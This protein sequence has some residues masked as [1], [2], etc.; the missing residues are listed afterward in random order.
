M[1]LDIGAAGE[2][3]N[4]LSTAEAT[5]IRIS[6]D[7]KTRGKTH[8]TYRELTEGWKHDSNAL[9]RFFARG[10]PIAGPSAGAVVTVASEYYLGGSTAY[11]I[12]KGD[13]SA[14]DTINLALGDASGS[15]GGTTVL[16][17]YGTFICDGPVIV[18]A[19]VTL[20][21]QGAATIISSS[22]T[23]AIQI[24]GGSGTEIG[25][26][27]IRDMQIKPS[28]VTAGTGMDIDYADDL[29]IENILITDGGY[30]IDIK[31]CDGVTLT[32]ITVNNFITLGF[33]IDST[34]KLNVS[35]C[36]IDGKSR[37]G[38]NHAYGAL[39]N[40]DDANLSNIQ[41]LNILGSIN[42]PFGLSAGGDR[43]SLANITIKNI[44][45]TDTLS[46]GLNIPGEGSTIASLVVDDVDNTS[47]TTTNA[48]GVYVFG[49]DN[50]ISGYYV[51]NGTG[52]GVVI[53]ATADRTMLSSGRSTNNVTNYTD[54]GTNTQTSSVDNT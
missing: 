36:I 6:A 16:M 31:N 32:G 37:A 15:A 23:D 42:N 4:I 25:G 38:N 19:G 24:T 27:T 3:E 17:T 2:T 10:V 12:E 5:G 28:D 13:T 53:S 9:A 18:P 33:L 41:V 21:G 22:A 45:S 54:G 14:E 11:R 34:T 50:V 46:F 52:S 49:D 44:T 1:L 39:I 43:N 51:T 47:G 30:G 7:A 48:Y 29:T 8:V 35:N 26:V 40:A 20:M